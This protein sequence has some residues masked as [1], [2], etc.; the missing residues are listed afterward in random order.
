VKAIQQLILVVL[1]VYLIFLEIIKS[2]S[3][4]LAISSSSTSSSSTWFLE[5]QTTENE[6]DITVTAFLDINHK[7]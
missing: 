5:V 6:P 3:N 2:G 4:R 7:F 1:I